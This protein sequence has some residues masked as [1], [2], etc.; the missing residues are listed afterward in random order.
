MLL[1]NNHIVFYIGPFKY[2]A[3]KISR[4][5]WLFHVGLRTVRVH[6]VFVIICRSFSAPSHLYA[7]TLCRGPSHGLS[8]RE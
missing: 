2:E 8:D 1:F 3:I 4:L 5:Q 6:C 7:P